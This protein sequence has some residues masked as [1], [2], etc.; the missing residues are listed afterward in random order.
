MKEWIS[1]EYF[2][3]KTMMAARVSASTVVARHLEPVTCDVSQFFPD[4]FKDVAVLL[5]DEEDRDFKSFEGWQFLLH[6]LDDIEDFFVPVQGCDRE[7]ESGFL[8]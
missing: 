8:C 6:R 3:G 7:R 1:S 4:Q 2:F 5:L